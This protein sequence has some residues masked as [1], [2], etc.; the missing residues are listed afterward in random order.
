MSFEIQ[1]MAPPGLEAVLAEEV[2]AAG[3]ATP[4]TVPGGVAFCGG[5]PEVWRANLDLRGAGRVSAVIASFRAFHPAQLDKRARRVDWGAVLLPDVPVRV[6]ATADR[7]SKVYHAGAARDRIARAIAEELG[8]PITEDAPVT[9]RARIVD[10]LVTLSVDTSGEP[11]HKRGH[12]Q[13]VGRAPMRET[14]AA[15]LLRAC[16]YVGSEPVLDPMCGSGT[17]VIEA[18]EM[19]AG[20]APGR[21]RGFA[22]ER[23]ASFDPAA[24]QAMRMEPAGP[25][26]A[27][28]FHGSDRDAGAFAA[29]RANAERAGVADLCSFE[30]KTISEIAPPEGAPGLVIVNPPY[31]T[32]VGDRKPLYALHAALGRVLSERFE[33]WRVG[34][35]TSEKSL[36][37][38]TDLPFASEGAPI[39]HGGLK[40]RLYRTD[41]L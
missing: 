28:R 41:P 38:A 5:W 17:F 8:A 9:V 18:A 11:L 13:A 22:F 1:A 23:L 40:V 10:N 30:R 37:H 4:R 3:F 33:G 35:V 7:R 15:L 24:W 39:P 34:I 14:M 27:L 20:L 26:P 16:G 31:G 2:R 19:A 29:A 32:R 12:K 36:A 6:E 25:P 21:S